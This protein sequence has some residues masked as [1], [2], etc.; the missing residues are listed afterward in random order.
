MINRANGALPQL[1]AFY[2]WLQA[3]QTGAKMQAV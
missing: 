2:N 1:I 3:N